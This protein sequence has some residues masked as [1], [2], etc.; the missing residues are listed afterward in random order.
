MPALEDESLTGVPE[1][2]PESPAQLQQACNK[3][4][5]DSSGRRRN[6]PGLV[7]TVPAEL[8]SGGARGVTSWPAP[9]PYRAAQAWVG[10]APAY[11]AESSTDGGS[12]GGDGSGGGGGGVSDRNSLASANE[13]LA[14]RYGKFNEAHR[15]KKVKVLISCCNISGS[16]PFR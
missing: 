12:D 9:V 4:E 5:V 3:A 6:A 11:S 15:V 1:P 14:V 10:F 16:H 2:S 7:P 8:L 13:A